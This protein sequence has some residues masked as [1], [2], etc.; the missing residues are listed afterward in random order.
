MMMGVRSGGEGLKGLVVRSSPAQLQH[1][2]DDVITTASRPSS[3]LCST[4]AAY[5]L[6]GGDAAFLG[7]AATAVTC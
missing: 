7:A 5:L 6:A 2:F 4:F 3:L 1:H